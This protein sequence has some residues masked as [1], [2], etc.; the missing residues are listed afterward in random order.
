MHNDTVDSHLYNKINDRRVFVLGDQVIH[1][2]SYCG[3]M[4]AGKSL[5]ICYASDGRQISAFMG[6]SGRI[7][8][9]FMGTS[10]GQ[11]GNFMGHFVLYLEINT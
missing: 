9:D 8:G 6:T 4:Y 2:H 10:W 11:H 3:H 5:A 1:V 7:H